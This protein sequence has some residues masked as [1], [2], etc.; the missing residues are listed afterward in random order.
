MV[1]SERYAA[2]GA[3]E[4]DPAPPAEA[5]L[6]VGLTAAAE[7]LPPS[8]VPATED[9]RERRF[10]IE[11]GATCGVAFGKADMAPGEI[12][13]ASRSPFSVG[14]WQPGGHQPRPAA[15]QG[16]AHDRLLI[17]AEPLRR[18]F[19]LRPFPF[20]VRSDLGARTARG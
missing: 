9:E 4:L 20:Y 2:V 12:E 17:D 15:L 13:L 5:G 14:S 3:G 8:A 1:C 11:V 7:V 10:G 6:M 19:R 18:G 16:E